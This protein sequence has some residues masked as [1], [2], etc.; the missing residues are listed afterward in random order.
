MFCPENVLTEIIN[1]S[2]QN[3]NIDYP[4]IDETIDDFCLEKIFNP[5][6][7]DK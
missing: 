2:D 5:D 3:S 1:C 4:T 6:N 7:L